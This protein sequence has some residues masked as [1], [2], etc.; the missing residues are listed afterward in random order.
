MGFPPDIAKRFVPTLVITRDLTR[1]RVTDRC[2]FGTMKVCRECAII[3]QF[4][5]YRVVSAHVEIEVA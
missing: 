4:R 3:Q 5:G 1:G 2:A